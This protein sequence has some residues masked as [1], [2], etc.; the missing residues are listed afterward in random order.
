M[1]CAHQDLFNHL[2]ILP[3]F[4]NHGK[5]NVKQ[6]LAENDKGGFTL[7]S[8]NLDSIL[9]ADDVINKP[10][11]VISVAGASLKGKSFLLDVLLR[12]L[13]APDW[14]KEKRAGFM[15]QSHDTRRHTTGMMLWSEP[16]PVTLPSGEEAVIL[17]VDTQGATDDESTAHR[18]QAVF[19]LSAL[20]SSLLIINVMDKISDD[21]V[22]QLQPML[23]YGQMMRDETCTSS[24]QKLLFLVRD[25]KK[26][27][28]FP[29]G[30][31][32]GDRLV[33]K[34]LQSGRGTKL[35]NVRDHLG[36]CF[37][38]I[39]GFL[40]PPPGEQVA[41]NPIFDGG[42]SDM[43]PAFAAGLKE[44]MPKILAPEHLAAKTIAGNFIKARDL[45]TFITSYVNLL[46]SDELPKPDVILQA[47]T[48]AALKTAVQEAKSQYVEEMKCRED[49]PSLDQD[50]LVRKHREAAKRAETAFNDRKKMGDD[51]ILQEH[52]KILVQEIGELHGLAEQAN[53]A[54][55]EK[56]NEDYIPG[57]INTCTKLYTSEMEG[58]V[59]AVSFVSRAEMNSAHNAAKD[60]AMTKFDVKI[61][62]HSVKWDCRF[63]LARVIGAHFRLM[64][65]HNDTKKDAENQSAAR[66]NMNA[67]KLAHKC[68]QV[69][70]NGTTSGELTKEELER[71][72]KQ[73]LQSA[74]ATFKS[75]TEGKEQITANYLDGLK[76]L[77]DEDLEMKKYRLPSDQA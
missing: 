1:M 15:K 68:Y 11:I 28:E 31:E 10:V 3:S 7:R 2:R 59:G 21:D 43:D 72:H 17:L 55:R 18:S 29:L 73:A 53:A 27:D 30:A 63:K 13:M 5:T 46:S 24:F 52:L 69:V 20:I 51:K 37:S 12:Y 23:E 75:L 57:L 14:L 67:V 26:S 19:A 6:I 22:K 65:H 62:G 66:A 56:E 47:T 39:N 38:D 71:R 61:K 45:H 41:S 25:W 60:K 49:Q 74:I 35:A 54:K 4:Q 70:V 64:L 40:L 76:K 48:E 44:L 32:G 16:L 77:T 8:K 9:L 34:W 58:V 50:E 42:S 36:D 33:A